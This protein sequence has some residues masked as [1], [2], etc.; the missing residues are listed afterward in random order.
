[1]RHFASFLLASFA[2]SVVVAPAMAAEAWRWK[3]DKGVVHYSDTPVPGAE[4]VVLPS[5]PAVGT[6]TPAAPQPRPA[7]PA[8]FRYNECVVLAPGNE[9]TFNAV[10]SVPATVRISPQLLPDHRIQ[11]VLDGDVYP[12][13][14]PRMLTSKLENLHR[15]EHTLAVQVVGAD[16]KPLCK[17]A[18]I[19]FHVRQPSL[20]APGKPKPKP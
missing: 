15:G 2:L 17:G 6:V 12:G 19:K 8:P 1:M 20:L 18:A 7:G 11:V 10:T 5:P 14:P 9:Q 3:D 13:W 4:R 16:K